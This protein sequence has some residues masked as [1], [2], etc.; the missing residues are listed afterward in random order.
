VLDVLLLLLI[1]LLLDDL[2]LPD[3]LRECVVV[4]C[5]EDTLISWE[6]D[7]LAKS[8]VLPLNNERLS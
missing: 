4:A 2:I 8:T 3:S 5:W 1:L 7:I 6:T